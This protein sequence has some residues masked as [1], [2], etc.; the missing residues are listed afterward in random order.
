MPNNAQGECSEV[1]F[2]SRSHYYPN[3]F[4]HFRAAQNTQF[5]RWLEM[6]STNNGQGGLKF[7]GAVLRGYR[8]FLVFLPQ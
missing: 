4:E 1:Y 2:K 5:C 6:G 3:L 8:Y 7:V